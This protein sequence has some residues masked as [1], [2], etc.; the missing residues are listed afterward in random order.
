MRRASILLLLGLT[1]SI[2]GHADAA[3][4][5]PPPIVATWFSTLTPKAGQQET[6]YVQVTRAGKPVS[7]GTMTATISYG[8]HRFQR[9]GTKTNKAGRSWTTFVVPIN[10]K[11]AT[12]KAATAVTVGGHTYRGSNHVTVKK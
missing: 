11:G 7:G 12:L 5:L 1:L 9:K 6:L 8:K 10:A 2:G 4:P 3:G